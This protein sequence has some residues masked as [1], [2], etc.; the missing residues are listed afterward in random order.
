MEYKSST[1]TGCVAGAELMRSGVTLKR[2]FWCGLFVLHFVSLVSADEIRIKA[3]VGESVFLPCCHEIPSTKSLHDYRVYWQTDQDVV[4]AYS[5]GD[6]LKRSEK[7]VNRTKMDQNNLTMSLFPVKLS[8]KDQ[9]KCIVQQK[10]STAGYHVLCEKIV[11]LDVVV[12]YSKP[13][14][15]A[16]IQSPCGSS[17]VMVT[18]LSHGGYPLPRVSGVLNNESVEWSTEISKTSPYN[19]TA[20]LQLNV[21]DDSTLTCIIEYDNFEV[22][23]NYTLRK[24][25]ECLP[26]LTPPSHGVIIACL[27]LICIFLVAI[28]LL[29]KY[30]W[31]RARE[32]VQCSHYPVP[33]D[34]AVVTKMKKDVS[35][36]LCEVT[37][38]AASD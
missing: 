21:T 4:L 1:K 35:G 22:S 16:D 10:G 2:W 8:D 6:L 27:V 30:V 3:K 38:E 29:L 14:I 9:Y 24:Q 32:H 7:Y 17:E 12:D 5:S 23:S 37:L 33:Q 31:C 25:N 19:V 28:I 26:L 15:S 18:C 34:P 20:T 13:L 36:D 11:L